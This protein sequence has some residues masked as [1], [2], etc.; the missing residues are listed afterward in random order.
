MPRRIT[1][2]FDLDLTLVEFPSDHAVLSRTLEEVTSVEGILERVLY[3][4]RSDRWIIEEAGRLAEL[5]LEGLFER[6][7]A[8]YTPIL[9][10]ALVDDP[11]VALPGVVAVLEA[12]RATDGVTSGIGTGGMRAN[13][14]LKL[15]SA[16][17][18][19]HFTPMRGAFGDLHPDRVDVFREAAENCGHREDGRLV[20]VGDTIRDV[21]AALALDAVAVGVATGHNTPD[22]LRTAGAHTVLPSMADLNATLAALLDG[23]DRLTARSTSP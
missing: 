1:V 8:V 7:E 19:P 23:A 21:A 5:P 18:E 2:V 4:G 20:F 14:L 17:L 3:H 22:E 12:L 15:A 16:G 11:A 9:R 6:Y 10:R 13:A